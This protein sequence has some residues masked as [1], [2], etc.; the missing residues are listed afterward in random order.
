[1][2]LSELFNKPDGLVKDAVHVPMTVSSLLTLQS[3]DP[4]SRCERLMSVLT[5][6]RDLAAFNKSNTPGLG[7]P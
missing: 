6:P 2:Y 3:A 7:A 5:N 1:M 4:P